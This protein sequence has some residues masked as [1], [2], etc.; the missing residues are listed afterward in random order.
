VL[1]VLALALFFTAVPVSQMNE[2]APAILWAIRLPALLDEARQVGVT[3]TVV[4]EVLNGLRGRGLSAGEA[5]MVLGEEV[6]AVNAGEPKDNFGGFVLQQ[7]DAGLRGRA[8]AQ[9]IRAEHQA[10]GK[11]RPG[12]HEPIG[13]DTARSGGGRP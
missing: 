2:A 8:L 4:A 1:R 3:E 12:G 13:R 6:D 11:G 10:R 7:L 9:A 5:A